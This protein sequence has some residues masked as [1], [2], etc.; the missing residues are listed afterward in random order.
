MPVIL[1]IT[2]DKTT[3][4][5]TREINV[6]KRNFFIFHKFRKGVKIIKIKPVTLLTKNLG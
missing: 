2:K 5:A 4:N 6:I 1:T 3:I